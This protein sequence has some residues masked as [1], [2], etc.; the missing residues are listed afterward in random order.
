MGLKIHNM[1]SELSK[2]HHMKIHNMKEQSQ[3]HYMYH[4]PGFKFVC[5]DTEKKS[6]I[7]SK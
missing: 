1:K 5:D 3:V 6:K 4:D 2:V 7:V